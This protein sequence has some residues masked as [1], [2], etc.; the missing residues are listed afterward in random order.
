MPPDL[1][2]SGRQWAMMCKVIE[3]LYDHGQHSA[4]Q[5]ARG[6][7]LEVSSVYPAMFLAAELGLVKRA[8]R[9]HSPICDWCGRAMH[10]IGPAE[11]GMEAQAGYRVFLCPCGHER[12]RPAPPPEQSEAA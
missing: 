10:D 8:D 3:Y 12:C 7:G 9:E 2:I 1:E 6:T 4:A 11:T 5:I